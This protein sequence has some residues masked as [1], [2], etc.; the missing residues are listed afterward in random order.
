[1]RRLWTHPGA[2][3]GVEHAAATA[4]VAEWDSGEKATELIERADRAL[5]FAKHEGERG[6][7]QRASL[8][9]AA[10]PALRRP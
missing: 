5:R 9:P 7:A 3:A 2:L 8:V 6:C 1:V 10:P 4:G